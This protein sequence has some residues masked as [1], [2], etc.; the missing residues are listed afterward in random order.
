MLRLIVVASLC[1]AL[2]GCSRGLL[3][4][5]DSAAPAAEQR[6]AVNNELVLPPDL[7]LRAPGT[8]VAPQAPQAAPSYV[9]P[10]QDANLY[11]TPAAPGR[12]VPGQDVYEKYGISV[13]KPDGSRKADWELRRELRAAIL[14]DKR[15]QNPNY[16]TIWNVGELFK[17]D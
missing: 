8:G 1:I 14:A 10:A 9:P 13:N 11:G 3:G 6:I 12:P 17:E 16:G 15:K 7:S 4:G 2:A 5:G